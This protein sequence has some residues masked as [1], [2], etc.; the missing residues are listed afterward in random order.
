VCEIMVSVWNFVCVRV[1]SGLAILYA[2]LVVNF[3][4]FFLFESVVSVWN[5]VCVRLWIV[6]GILCM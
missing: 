3:G 5:F 4:N 6:L 2:V 1:C